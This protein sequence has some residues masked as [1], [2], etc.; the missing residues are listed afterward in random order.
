MQTNKVIKSD[1]FM[2]LTYDYLPNIDLNQYAGVMH[3]YPLSDKYSGRPQVVED[4][5]VIGKI[6]SNLNVKCLINTSFNVHGNP[7]VYDLDD[8]INNFL[9]QQKINKKRFNNKLIVVK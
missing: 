7:I 1:S 4:S 9:F 6:I 3:K 5:S 8:A 2:I